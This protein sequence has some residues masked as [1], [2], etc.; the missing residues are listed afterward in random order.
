[1]EKIAQR[2][3]S[4]LLAL[5]PTTFRKEFGEEMQGVFEEKLAEEKSAGSVHLLSVIFREFRDLAIRAI[6]ERIEEWKGVPQIMS[7]PRLRVRMVLIQTPILLAALLLIY[8]PRYL[9]HFVNDVLGWEILG[10]IALG[11][12][13][14]WRIWTIPSPKTTA[15]Y[16]LE[17]LGI[18]CLILFMNLLIMLG[19]ALII[20]VK[21]PVSMTVPPVAQFLAA[22]RWII[23]GLDFVLLVV[24]VYLGVMRFRKPGANVV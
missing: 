20:L 6:P 14:G 8:N 12:F 10:A 18:L 15:K 19:P 22:M 21:A 1:L 3:Y 11:L 2:F 7:T 16:I 5:Y 13:I 9:L 17:E 23:L 4:L 24:A